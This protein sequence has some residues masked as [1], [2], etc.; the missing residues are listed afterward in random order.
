MGDTK[1]RPK[2]LSRFDV[3]P[4][5]VIS[6]S[7]DQ[8]LHIYLPPNQQLSAPPAVYYVQPIQQSTGLSMP[9][10]N[11]HQL[12]PTIPCPVLPSMQM[13]LPV[14]MSP[15]V[16][17]QQELLHPLADKLQLD[18]LL[19]YNI[20]TKL[21]KEKL[22]V[23]LQKNFDYIRR[24]DAGLIPIKEP[25]KV[26]STHNNPIVSRPMI[27]IESNSTSGSNN[28]VKS[29]PN[30]SA[31]LLKSLDYCSILVLHLLFLTHVLLT[32]SLI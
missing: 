3:P 10:Y 8:L 22:E 25:V 5:E 7:V 29:N 6:S 32:D 11:Y 27:G 13:D 16:V 19:V 1:E 15:S 23:K 20:V 14:Y 28:K 12:N 30:V 9:M 4:S 21:Y 26:V 18:P 24:K 2:K 17:Q 31:Q